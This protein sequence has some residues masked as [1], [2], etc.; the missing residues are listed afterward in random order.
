[1]SERTVAIYGK[2]GCPFTNAAREHFGGLG[3]VVEY[4]NV[5]KDGER[6]KQLLA[7]SG[8][9]R[10]VPVIV[11]DGRVRIGFGGT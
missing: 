9:Q 10:K 7:Y 11:E 5:K 2:D 4:F 8:G 1:M 6:L 3:Y